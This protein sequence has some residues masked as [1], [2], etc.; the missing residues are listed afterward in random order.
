MS[1]NI[2]Y[3]RDEEYIPPTRDDIQ[4]KELSPHREE[5]N[6]VVFNY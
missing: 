4:V 5:K 2:K 1:Q 6:E 3:E